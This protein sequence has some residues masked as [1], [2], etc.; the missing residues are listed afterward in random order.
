MIRGET[1]SV[2]LTPH[3]ATNLDPF[4]TAAPA[5]LALRNGTITEAGNWR[6]RPGMGGGLT[7]GGGGQVILL[8]PDD[9][10]YAMGDTGGTYLLSVRGTV[11]DAAL[12]LGAARA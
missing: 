7:C 9:P 1:R 3:R 4:E 6:K 8:I 2:L 10:G 12:G 11:V 5:H